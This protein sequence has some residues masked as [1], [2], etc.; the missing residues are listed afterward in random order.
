MKREHSIS[1]IDSTTDYHAG[2]IRRIVETAWK[3][4]GYPIGHQRVVVQYG[5]HPLIAARR[6]REVPLQEFE[7]LRAE[8]AMSEPSTRGPEPVDESTI[9]N[10]M[11]LT[12]PRDPEP[13][14]PLVVARFISWGIAIAAGIPKHE[15]LPIPLIEVPWAT[16]MVL[17]RRSAVPPAKWIQITAHRSPFERLLAIYDDE[18]WIVFVRSAVPRIRIRIDHIP[19]VITTLNSMAE[20]TH[21][22]APIYDPLMSTLKKLRGHALALRPRNKKEK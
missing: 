10:F 6:G 7:A 19:T 1:I 3:R 12:L 9:A 4:S 17:R 11:T 2:D 21:T 13:D 15:V 20:V 5:K 16:G 8:W 18:P 14:L 22:N